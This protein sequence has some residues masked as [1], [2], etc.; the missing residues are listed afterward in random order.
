MRVLFE[1]VRD[2]V[3]VADASTG[4]I[5]LWNRAATDLFGYSSSE[6]LEMRV[7]ALVP[8][9]L[10]AR[11]RVG[12][13]RYAKVGH[14]PHIDSH[15]ML[16]V[17]AVRKD[18]G[19]ISIELSLSP[20]NRLTCTN[21]EESDS[22]FVLAVIRD[23][24]ERKRAEQEIR[25]LNEDLENRVAE[26]TAELRVALA[27]RKRVE[28]DLRRSESSL[29]AAQRIAHLGNWEYNVTENKAW[30][31][32]ELYRIFGYAPQR[33]LPTYKTFLD[34][35]HPDDRDFVRRSVRKA[36]Y[37][38]GQGSVDYRIVRPNGEVRAVQTCYEG[39]RDAL[40]RPLRLIGTVHDV[41]ERKQAEEQL[42]HQ[43]LHDPLTGLPNRSLLI[44]HLKHALAKAKRQGG[45]VAVLFLI[46]TPSR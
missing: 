26:R 17:P 21:H 15:R 39:V 4:R 18:G 38:E 29:A 36:L 43:A 27:Q 2:A 42:V 31:S 6:A 11:H 1:D 23:I 13:T 22:R 8:G 5:V 12:M 30:W 3:V 44:E 10:K 41:T 40:N 9:Y 14:G 33:F 24:T 32:D 37:T 20:T 35:V 16:D 46:W 25:R 45:R 7:E 34:S 28:E 19:E